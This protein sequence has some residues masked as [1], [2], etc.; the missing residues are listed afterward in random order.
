MAPELP[1]HCYTW[2]EL[3]FSVQ[4]SMGKGRQG[5]EPTEQWAVLSGEMVMR[6]GD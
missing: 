3:C 6:L 4:T 1:L 5:L 2:L